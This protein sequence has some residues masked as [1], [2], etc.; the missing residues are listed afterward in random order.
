VQAAATLHDLKD[1]FVQ[2]LGPNSF[3]AHYRP[4][5]SAGDLLLRH[6]T[7]GW[8]WAVCAAGIA[9][10]ITGFQLAMLMWSMMEDIIISTDE[11]QN[12]QV[13]LYGVDISGSRLLTLPEVQ[14]AASFAAEAHK[15]QVRK[16]N[17]PYITH[18]IATAQI[19]E[20][21]M[22]PHIDSV[23]A[24][25]AVVCAVLHDVI[26]DTHIPLE[27][28]QGKFGP[29]VASIV[30]KVSHLSTLNQL[31]RRRRRLGKARVKEPLMTVDDAELR[32]LILGM[33]DEPLVI[34]I[35]L[36]DRLHNMRTI[37]AL[38]PTKQTAVAQETLD[39][40]C[41][42]AERLGMFAIK[43]E[44]ED[45]CFAVLQP[46]T[47]HALHREL[48]SFW[49]SGGG[50]GDSSQDALPSVEESWGDPRDP[51]FISHLLSTVPRFEAVTFS[52]QGQQ[53]RGQSSWGLLDLE[54]CARKLL[55]ELSM[56]SYADGLDV[57]VHGRL[58]S[59]YSVHG[60]MKRKG[61]SA[62]EIYDARAL[63]V[64]VD[65]LNGK[66]EA[67]AIAACYRLLPAVHRLWPPVRG[68]TDDY[69]ANPKA[70]GYQSLH[71][72]VLGPGNVPLEI[73]IRTS[74]M[75]ELA[76]YGTAAHWVYKEGM[77]T[78]TSGGI[79]KARPV[80][81]QPLLRID[82]GSLRD[83]V[84]VQATNAGKRMLC[85]SFMGGRLSS[86]GHR[87]SLEDYRSLL[88]YVEHKGWA[89]AGLGDT[90]IALEDFILCSD[91]QYHRIDH[92]G[93]ILATRLQ[94]LDM[95]VEAGLTRSWGSRREAAP[96]SSGAKGPESSWSSEQREVKEKIHLLRS[97]LEW[98][99]QMGDAS[100]MEPNSGDVMVLLWPRGSIT[101]LP[102][103]TTAGQFLSSQDPE[104][105]KNPPSKM[106]NVNNRLVP[107][108]TPL[109]DG[110][111]VFEVQEILNI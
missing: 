46:E 86:D 70:S 84:V 96:S 95:P 64:V 7:A 33:V 68:E 27:E 102:R 100:G 18:C 105:G 36:A 1:K 4:P 3:S 21:L 76:E 40:W 72:A 62:R 47:Y 74:S 77:P 88:D 103:G 38:S 12:F 24:S 60:K 28:V 106:V 10:I 14:V 89:K 48:Q 104:A 50:S 85:A 55:Q 61:V 32:R 42:L 93:H 59:L 73:Q 98:G 66:R 30:S 43:A 82:G 69:I 71:T 78:D 41:S 75:H 58:K 56:E 107:G 2:E 37:Y 81:G 79:I 97:M 110:D 99:R 26:D 17:E 16:T 15:G 20:A 67:A 90:M 11:T 23:R 8:Y 53:L 6:H 22:G 83:G 13:L 101:R 44:L 25:T 35:K 80:A 91:G 5:L 92:C 63:R 29:E 45:L 9:L 34:L 87:P 108:A 31:L 52:S 94:L 57:Y 19:V 111:M 54:R 65:D 49:E 51:D 39:L 109:Q